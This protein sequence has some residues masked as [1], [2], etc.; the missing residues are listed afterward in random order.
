MSLMTRIVAEWGTRKLA[1]IALGPPDEI[2]TT[3]LLHVHIYAE[4]SMILSW[5]ELGPLA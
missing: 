2:D 4:D 1:T 3:D 5:N